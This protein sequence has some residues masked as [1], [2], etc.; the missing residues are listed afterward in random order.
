MNEKQSK[1]H[2]NRHQNKNIPQ[3]IWQIKIKPLP[4]QHQNKRCHSSVGRA[5]D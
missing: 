3:K 4:L 5:K 2:K 1:K